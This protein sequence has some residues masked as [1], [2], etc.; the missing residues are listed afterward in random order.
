MAHPT[1]LKDEKRKAVV[2]I[3]DAAVDEHD[4]LC[5]EKVLPIPIT[6]SLTHLLED[7]TERQNLTN[8]YHIFLCPDIAKASL[9]LCETLRRAVS[10]A[11]QEH[12]N[13]ETGHLRFFPQPRDTP[14]VL[15]TKLAS[16][17]SFFAAA[18]ITACQKFVALHLEHLHHIAKR[19]A[20]ESSGIWEPDAEVAAPPAQYRTR[21]AEGTE[22][23]EVFFTPLSFAIFGHHLGHEHHVGSESWMYAGFLHQWFLLSQLLL[24]K[25][26]PFSRQ[27]NDE[28]D[29]EAEV[30]QYE[31]EPSQGDQQAELEAAQH[32][33][34]QVAVSAIVNKGQQPTYQ[35]INLSSGPSQALY[36]CVL[37][38]H[39]LAWKE[40]PN[41]RFD[42][43]KTDLIVAGFKMYNSI[44]APHPVTNPPLEVDDITSPLCPVQQIREHF[45][46]G[47]KT[48]FAYRLLTFYIL[49]RGLALEDHSR[50][51]QV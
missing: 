26:D 2:H 47:C 50:P 29:V 35:A 10:V 30:E 42:P 33:D 17:M 11:M 23:T 21:Y 48:S 39:A 7:S 37:V 8:L 24:F 6:S 36:T 32:H 20:E 25:A 12:L 49:C 9:G 5:I 44:F 27:V 22:G 16:L 46:K 31:L 4:L 1:R 19:Q 18:S 45:Y 51:R 41:E 15:D 28:D 40:E 38:A 43:E 34:H 13:N 3:F 14:A